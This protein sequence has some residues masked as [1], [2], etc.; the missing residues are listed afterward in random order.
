MTLPGSM[1]ARPPCRPPIIGIVGGIGA[2]KSEVA[3]ILESLGCVVTDSDA[4]AKAALRLP[5]VRDQLVS[6][7]GSTILD[8]GG[9][10]DRAAIASIV[11][12]DPGERAKLERLIHPL[13]H[14]SRVK[15]ITRAT[16]S[17]ALA[18]VIDAPLLFEAGVDKECDAVLFVDTPEATRRA[19]VGLTRGWEP[20]ELARR[21]SSQLPLE[22][23]KI[24]ST[25]VLTN[26]AGLA[27]LKTRTARV[28]SE[29]LAFCAGVRG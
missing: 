27:D 25:H 3:R 26:D 17:G 8:P 6:W 18:V 4:E 9:N 21:E 12:R 28:L 19:R 13:V 24:R 29:I 20:E 1:P 22:Q 7:W 14:A 2:G 16:Q 23:K 10:P 5:Q 15:A 11:F